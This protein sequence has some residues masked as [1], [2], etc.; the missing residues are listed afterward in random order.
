[1]FNISQSECIRCIFRNDSKSDLEYSATQTEVFFAET[2][3]IDSRID[4]LR[5]Y[6][7]DDE[8]IRAEK[9]YSDIERRTYIACHALLR[10]IL[11]SRL[12]ID[13]LEL[14]FTKSLSNK[15]FLSEDLAFFNISHT[16]EAF[17]IAFARDFH[18]GIDLEK[19]NQNINF[20]TIIKN[21]FSLK[22]CNYVLDSK[23][24]EINRFFLLWTRKE[25]LLKAI[26]TGIINNLDQI[27][28]FEPSNF[29]ES[30]IFD[31]MAHGPVSSEYFIYSLK[32]MNY[33]LSVAI[34]NKSYIMVYYLDEEN[35]S[36][37]FSP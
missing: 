28:V 32:V 24:D 16:R 30:R 21:H 3:S 26:G 11:S 9:F 34:P 37:Y 31:N 1:M 27:T 12:K 8:V 23:E 35:L 25:S 22:E 15:P 4:A 6:I 5:K 14:T 18:L 19:I 10:L 2:E 17:A 13:P 7:S 33:F 36:T 29:I 20:H